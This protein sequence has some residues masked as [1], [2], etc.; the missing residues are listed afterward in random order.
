MGVLVL[1]NQ[2]YADFAF[3]EV[4]YFSFEDNNVHHL[5]PLVPRLN[6]FM[7]NNAALGVRRLKKV[8]TTVAIDGYV[9]VA[10]Y[11]SAK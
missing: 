3:S 5:E 6:V 4:R 10:L 7:R 9:F 11:G 1:R 2:T 8:G